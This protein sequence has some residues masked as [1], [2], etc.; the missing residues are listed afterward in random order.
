[1]YV[2]QKLYYRVTVYGRSFLFLL[3]I[4]DKFANKLHIALNIE[5]NTYF[6]VIFDTFENINNRLETNLSGSDSIS[7]I[8]RLL[9]K[10]LF[11]I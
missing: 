6:V 2:E 8:A 10:Y 5:K 3:H 9:G 11:N 4:S 1:M 7:I